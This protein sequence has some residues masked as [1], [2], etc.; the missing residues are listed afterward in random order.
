[1]ERIKLIYRIIRAP[2]RLGIFGFNLFCYFLTALPFTLLSEKYPYKMRKILSRVVQFYCY[3]TT[4]IFRM[5]VKVHGSR[6]HLENN[7]NYFVVANH[8]SY[9]DIFIFSSV[10]PAS[11]VTSIEMKK[12]PVLGHAAQAAACLYTERRN[13]DNIHKEIQQ[14]TDGL[15]NDLSVFVFP[16]AKSTNGEEVIMFRKSMFNAPISAQKEILPLT[17]NYRL[18]SGEEITLDNRDKVFWYDD[19]TFGPHF[20]KFLLEDHIDVDITVHDPVKPQPDHCPIELANELHVIVSSKYEKV[21]TRK[22]S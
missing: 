7:Q 8:L 1:M 4:K 14:V 20:A 15:I 22:N 21:N 12:T 6:H 3:T 11:F 16:E 9:L 2:I 5:R 10:V 18:I 17:I 13:R 19:M